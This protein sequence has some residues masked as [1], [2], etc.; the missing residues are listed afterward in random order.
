VW[1]QEKE[2]W[3]ALRLRLEV[4]YVINATSSLAL[5]KDGL[6]RMRGRLLSNNTVAETEE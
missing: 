2:R 5:L 6:I 3:Y 1:R 4:F